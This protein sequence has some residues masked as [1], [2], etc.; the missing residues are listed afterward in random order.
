M[1]TK[2]REEDEELR[3][4]TDKIIMTCVGVGYSNLSKTMTWL[5]QMDEYYTAIIFIYSFT[6]FYLI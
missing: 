6:N 2:S 1:D 5:I 3:L 4:G